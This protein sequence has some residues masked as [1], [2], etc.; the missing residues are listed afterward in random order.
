VY[1]S[2]VCF[3]SGIHPSTAVADIPDVRALVRRIKRAMEVNRT[4]GRQVTTGD[5]RRGREHWVY[6]R[7]GRP[8]RR[9]RTPIARAEPSDLGGRVTYW[10]PSCQPRRAT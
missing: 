6:G 5:L 1:K 2:E 8:C 9:C 7:G 4:I 3:L 10:C